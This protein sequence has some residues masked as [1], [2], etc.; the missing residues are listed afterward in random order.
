MSFEVY[1][2]HYALQWHKTMHTGAALLHRW[3][4]ALE[5]YDFTV[6]HRSGKIQTHVRGLSR[7]PVD[8]P[9]P[10]DTV[11]QIH[12]V[13]EEDEARRIARELHT[14][15]HLRGHAPWKLFLD[16]YSHKAGLCICL[17]VA[18]SCPRCQ[19]GTDYGHRQKTTGTIQSQGPWDTLSIDIVGPLPAANGRKEFLIVF[20]DCFWKY[21]ILVPSSNHT[22]NTVSKALMRHVIPYFG[23]PRRLLSDRGREFISSIWTQLL[24]TLG[25]QQVLTSPY[26]P[27][28]NAINEWSHRTLNNMLRARL[29]E[30]SST[31][32]WV[33]KIP[34]I[35]L[36]LNAMPH[37]PHGF[38]A[39]MIATGRE[40]TL[41]P[42]LAT[43]A[44]PSPFSEDAP[45]YIEEIRQRLQLTHQQM[46]L[47]PIDA[48]PNPYQEGSLVY[49]VTPPPERTS[50]MMP[51][52]KGPYSVCRVPNDYQV[53]YDDNGV[54]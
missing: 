4:A 23:T 51:R 11:L 38:S 17:E 47:P 35:M 1:T 39:S 37:E 14:A 10:E 18:Q 5:E 46:T 8:P 42:D 15:T 25:I 20:V 40:P 52:W 32:A 49:I 3:S 19:L 16:R 9:P 54:E 28:G 21:T 7:L 2:D 41:P 22:A 27:E 29:L 26:H 6:K 24:R 53:V 50:K 13:E 48:P 44:N 45:D 12:V 36:T 31:K 30:G 34:G 33:D 43:E